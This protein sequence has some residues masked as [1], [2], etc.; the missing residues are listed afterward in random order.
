MGRQHT[1]RGP[2]GFGHGAALLQHP[3]PEAVARQFQRSGEANNTPSGD[4]DFRSLH[5]SIV[6]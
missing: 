5:S 3:D 2:G 6:G 4:D 1:R